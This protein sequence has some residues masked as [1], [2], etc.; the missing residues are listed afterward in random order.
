MKY[1]KFYIKLFIP[2]YKIERVIFL[3]ERIKK[4]LKMFEHSDLEV[5]IRAEFGFL[6]QKKEFESYKLEYDEI[7]FPFLIRNDVD[8]VSTSSKLIKVFDD[9]ISI[10]KC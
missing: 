3:C 6:L 8:L 4:P 10:Y 7:I 1:S 5:K 2:K 9:L